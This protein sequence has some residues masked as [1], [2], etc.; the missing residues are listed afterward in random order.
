MIPKKKVG[1]G[2]LVLLAGGFSSCL[3]VPLASCWSRCRFFSNALVS[4][5]FGLTQSVR[6]SGGLAEAALDGV[7]VGVEPA[8]FVDLVGHEFVL[9]T[10]MLPAQV[11]KLARAASVA[12]FEKVARTGRTFVAVVA[13]GVR[14]GGFCR[15]AVCRDCRGRTAGLTSFAHCAPRG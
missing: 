9:V 12:A 1:V 15:L 4:T 14:R 10:G 3:D 7:R 5:R 6:H 13:W 11:G 2:G 8:D